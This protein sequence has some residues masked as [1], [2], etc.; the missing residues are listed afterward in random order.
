MGYA[1]G[2]AGD[3]S[4]IQTWDMLQ[5][6]DTAVLIDVRSAAE[7]SFVGVPDLT[8][9]GKQ[10]LFI[11]WQSFPSMQLNT[12]FVAQVTTKVGQ[13]SAVLCLCRSGARSAAAA[14]ALTATGFSK[15][16]NIAY[17]FE[18]DMNNEGHRGT[19][20]GW[21]ADALPWRQS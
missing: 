3:V 4:P 18:G 20:N 14:A 13:D 11:E 10:A 6:D 8:R 12:D 5:A 7:W 1:G 15:A 21:K 17:G 19:T 9:V 16:Y 2:Y